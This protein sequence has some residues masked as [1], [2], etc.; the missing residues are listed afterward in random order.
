MDIDVD[1]YLSGRQEE[2]SEDV[3]YGNED[4]H[5]LACLNTFAGSLILFLQYAYSQLNMLAERSRETEQRMDQL[6]TI[7]ERLSNQYDRHVAALVN[8]QK[9]TAGILNHELE[10]HALN[11]AIEALV[12]L[13]KELT[14][15]PERIGQSTGGVG[16]E[17]EFA[18]IQQEIDISCSIAREQ[19]AHLDIEIIAPSQAQKFDKNAHTICGCVETADEH[20]HGKISK[21]VTPGIVYRGKVLHQARVSVFRFQKPVNKNSDLGG[22]QNEEENYR[23]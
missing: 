12:K 2:F 5:S 14:D 1:E 21:L 16:T 23:Y 9:E 15:L 10:R 17:K 6:G 4:Q 7:V 22:T 20:Q 8:C 13:A 18:G 19:L 11:P 3:E